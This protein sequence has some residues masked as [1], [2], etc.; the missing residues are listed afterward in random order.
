MAVTEKKRKEKRR[1]ARRERRFEILRQDW[2]EPWLMLAGDD[3]VV[4]R[5][6]SAYSVADIV[7]NEL[8][9]PQTGR[10]GFRIAGNSAAADKGL[11]ER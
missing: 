3:I 11:L 1:R 2:L 5:T 7:T 4:G 6:L 9:V 8:K 10:L